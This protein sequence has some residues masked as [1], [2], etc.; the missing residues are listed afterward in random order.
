MITTYDWF[1]YD[2]PEKERYRLIGEC[3]FDGVLLWWSEGFGRNDYRN[4]P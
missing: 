1:G 2:L 3:G 4:G